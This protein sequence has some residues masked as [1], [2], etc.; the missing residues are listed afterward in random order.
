MSHIAVD[1]KP[2]PES[3]DDHHIEL[4]TEELRGA[5]H[6]ALITEKSRTL[7]EEDLARVDAT[8][9]KYLEQ[10]LKLNALKHRKDMTSHPEIRAW[11]EAWWVQ[12]AA[13][14]TIFLLAGYLYLYQLG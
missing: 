3:H 7:N 2:F 10:Q 5:L 12:V 14:A 11:H 4:P 6:Q 1:N 13:G 8:V 9:G